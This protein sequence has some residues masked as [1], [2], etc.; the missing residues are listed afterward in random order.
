MRSTAK[1]LL[2]LVTGHV[3]PP[4]RAISHHLL[5]SATGQT[6]P[7]LWLLVTVPWNGESNRA[8]FSLRQCFLA[9]SED[10]TRQTGPSRAGKMASLWKLQR[11]RSVSDKDLA[12][13]AAA[14]ESHENP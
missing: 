2:F 4:A 11:A 10:A 1:V 7:S 12:V 6:L 9:T 13:V 8:R 14:R 5:H 3:V